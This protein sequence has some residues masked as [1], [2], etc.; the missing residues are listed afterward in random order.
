MRDL[1]QKVTSG[2]GSVVSKSYTEK[3]FVLESAREA[4]FIAPDDLD[5]TYT[6]NSGTSQAGVFGTLTI[7]QDLW[8]LYIFHGQ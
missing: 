4:T 1:T 7:D 8:S 2:S 6:V 3:F 5:Y